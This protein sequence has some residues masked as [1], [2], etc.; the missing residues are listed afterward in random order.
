MTRGDQA[1][2]APGAPGEERAATPPA[3]TIPAHAES[4]VPVRAD[5]WLWSARLYPTRSAATAACRGGHVRR[6][7]DPIKAAQRLSVGDELR[8][9]SPGRE[10]IV[11]ITRLLSKRVGAQI[12]RL[13]YEDR[14][15]EP[16]AQMLTAPPRRERGAG[17]P[18]KKERREM[19]RW[20]A[21]GATPAGSGRSADA[22]DD[23]DAL[24]R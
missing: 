2:S 11:V 8:L 1:A 3:P 16:I 15:P 18:T 24:E 20:R 4:A 19:D 10:R 14:S 17:R 5:L 6:G 22:E 23:E 9:R 21:Q 12:A 7:G 13:A